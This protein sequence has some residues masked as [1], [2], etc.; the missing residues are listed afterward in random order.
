MCNL[1]NLSTLVQRW[2]DVE[3]IKP[4]ENTDTRFIGLDFLTVYSLI[5]KEQHDV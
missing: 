4:L 2:K 5:S 3:G 1:D